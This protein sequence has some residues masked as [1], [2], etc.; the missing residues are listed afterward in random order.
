MNFDEKKAGE[1]MKEKQPVKLFYDKDGNISSRIV[2]AYL[3]IIP[4]MLLIFIVVLHWSFKE[5]PLPEYALKI[6]LRCLTVLVPLVGALMGFQSWEN[7]LFF[8]DLKNDKE[9]N[10]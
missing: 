9:K 4:L 8:K 3:I 6:I 7:N 10:D 1:D 2:L 5:H